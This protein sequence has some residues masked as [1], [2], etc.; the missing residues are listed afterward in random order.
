M[1]QT[2]P[3]AATFAE[4]PQSRAE[5]YKTICALPVVVDP[6][7]GRITMP[8]GLVKAIMMPI[9]LAERVKTSLDLR[10][11]APLS[12]IGHPRA[13]MWT[14]L[15][16]SDIRPI[17]D[18][19]VVAQLWRARVLVIH[20]GDIALPSPASDPGLIRTWVSPATGVF[21]PSGAV[22]IQ[23]ALACLSRQTAR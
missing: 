19:A 7:T 20:D 22:V 5:F 18:P 4:T 1:T 3:P 6:S 9:P 16:R 11:I 15:A 17:G 21:R 13:G 14:F 12:I 10:G 8:T 23:C 2:I